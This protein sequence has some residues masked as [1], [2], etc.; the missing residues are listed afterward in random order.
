MVS[1][2]TRFWQNASTITATIAIRVMTHLTFVLPNPLVNTTKDS[3]KEH[4][5]STN[6]VYFFIV[7]FICKYVKL[8]AGFRPCYHKSMTNQEIAKMF[9]EIARLLE[10]K[11]DSA[12]RINANRT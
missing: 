3:G 8:R 4:P 1:W 12:Y 11:G 9:T 6:F 5:I 2:A 10:I 7:A